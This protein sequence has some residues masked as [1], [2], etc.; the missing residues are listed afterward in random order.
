MRNFVGVSLFFLV[1]LGFLTV[2]MKG[3]SGLTWTLKACMEC[4][5]MVFLLLPA[6]RP[7]PEMGRDQ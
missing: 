6:F 7:N 3:S 4:T 1:A 2:F 5:G